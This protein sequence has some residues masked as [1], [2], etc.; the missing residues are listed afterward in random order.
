[1]CWL[2]TNT[3]LDLPVMGL[4]SMVLICWQIIPLWFCANTHQ[5]IFGRMWVFCR[6]NDFKVWVGY[7]F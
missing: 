6:Y 3:L 5:C 7:R 1:M 4:I 2:G